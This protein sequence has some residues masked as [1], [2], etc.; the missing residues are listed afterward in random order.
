MKNELKYILGIINDLQR[1]AEAKHAGLIV[2]NS[3]IIIG[4]LSSFSNI[5]IYEKY[6]VIISLSLLGISIFGSLIAQFPVT[7]NVH[8]TSQSIN[9]PNLY[10]FEHLSKISINEFINE[11][12]ISYPSFIADNSDQNIINQ[13]L[14]NAKITSTKFFVFKYCIYTSTLGIGLLGISTLIKVL[15]HL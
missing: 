8:N 15:W 10:Y 7:S 3:A 6:S 13:I 14:V 11:F 12:I 4:V 9:G 1:F 5:H 2:L